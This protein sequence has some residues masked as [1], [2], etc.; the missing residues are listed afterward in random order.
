MPVPQPTLLF[1]PRI[2]AS[3]DRLHQLYQFIEVHQPL[4]TLRVTRDV[5]AWEYDLHQAM[6]NI[7]DEIDMVG[8]DAASMDA[9]AASDPAECF[10]VLSEYFFSAPELLENRFPAVYRHFCTFY[11]QDPLARLKRGENE[12][13]NIESSS[14]MG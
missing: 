7:Q 9:Y 12:N 5:A 6:D 14:P 4:R 13:Q 11:R 3:P 1:L 10:A 8:V 2:R